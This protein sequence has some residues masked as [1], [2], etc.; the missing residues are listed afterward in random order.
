MEG[1]HHNKYDNPFISKME[2]KAQ[3]IT[4]IKPDIAVLE[5]GYSIEGACPR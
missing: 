5:S 2:L 3:L 4:L 1:N